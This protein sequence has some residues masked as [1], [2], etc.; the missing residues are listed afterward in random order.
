[1]VTII[2]WPAGTRTG[3]ASAS[4]ARAGAQTEGGMV[5]FPRLSDLSFGSA[6]TVPSRSP[7]SLS[8]RY[9]ELAGRNKFWLDGRLMSSRQTGVFYFTL[10]R[11]VG[12]MALFFCSD[13]PFLWR[14]VSHQM[15]S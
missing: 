3:C 7:S 10:V 9:E 15:R 6:K 14:E 5:A 8:L 13:G 12:T 4:G 11:I 2:H 1:M